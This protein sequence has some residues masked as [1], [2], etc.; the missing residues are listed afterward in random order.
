MD[1]HLTPN[2]FLCFRG[3]VVGLNWFWWQKTQQENDIFYGY[4]LPTSPLGVVKCMAQ[5]Y[6]DRFYGQ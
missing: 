4:Y 2:I 5:C 1:T 3:N 6:L